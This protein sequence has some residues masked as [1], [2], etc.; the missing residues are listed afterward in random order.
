MKRQKYYAVRCGRKP[1]VY[2][3]WDECREQVQF[4]RFA[5][6][7]AFYN[8]NAALAY[9]NASINNYNHR[10]NNPRE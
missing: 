8:Y 2:S 4:Y 1:G 10:L 6:Y 3:T 5:D 9:A 7:R